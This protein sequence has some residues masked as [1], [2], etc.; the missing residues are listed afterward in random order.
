[1]KEYHQLRKVHKERVV[2]WGGECACGR[3]AVFKPT[4]KQVKQ[5]WEDHAKEKGAK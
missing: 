2:G 1:V 5:A 3:W 4:E